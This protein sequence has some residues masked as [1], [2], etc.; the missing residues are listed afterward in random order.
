MAKT[1]TVKID[2]KGNIRAEVNGTC[3]PECTNV[4]AAIQKAM[5]A[6]GTVDHK[7]EYNEQQITT[8]VVPDYAVQ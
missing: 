2:K 7:P 4:L 3:G 8:E 6:D 1:V 5:G